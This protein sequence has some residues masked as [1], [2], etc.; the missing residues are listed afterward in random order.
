MTVYV[1]LWFDDDFDAVNDVAYH[2]DIVHTTLRRVE[3]SYDG[4]LNVA[5]TRGDERSLGR[6]LKY[7]LEVLLGH[8]VRVVPL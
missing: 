1:L 8:M 7:T 5:H 4:T 3:V 6:W 2:T